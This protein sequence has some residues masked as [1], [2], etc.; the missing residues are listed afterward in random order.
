M[1]YTIKDGVKT[2]VLN[3]VIL[4]HSSSKNSRVKDRWVEFTIYKTPKGQYVV[5]R[6]GMSV[7]Y[8]AEG[9]KSIS[10]HGLSAIDGDTLTSANIP[11]SDCNPKPT[12][13]NKVYPEVS[14]PFVLVCNSPHG[15]IKFMHKIDDFG[16]EYL[17]NVAKDALEDAADMDEDMYA[18]YYTNYI[19]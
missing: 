6:I 12:P 9:C 5:S 14:R 18:A 8:H 4:G 11:C 16:V 15:V 2:H 19:E 17:T 3:A 7:V 13:E 1:L 10:K